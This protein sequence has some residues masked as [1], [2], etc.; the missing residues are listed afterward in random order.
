M[1]KLTAL[2]SARKKRELWIDKKSS[3]YK[4]AVEFQLRRVFLSPAFFAHA[5][6]F[7]RAAVPQFY[8]GLG[9]PVDFPFNLEFS[10]PPSHRLAGSPLGDALRRCPQGNA[11][12]YSLRTCPANGIQH[13]LDFRVGHKQ[14]PAQLRAIVLNHNQNRALVDGHAAGCKPVLR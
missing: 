1:G 13:R 12:H 8:T 4:K 5:D 2:S 7:H 14:I 6:E 10:F 3:C 11:V 9:H